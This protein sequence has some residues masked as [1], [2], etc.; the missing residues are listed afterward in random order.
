[1][2]KIWYPFT[3]TLSVEAVHV[4]LTTVADSALAVNA[5]GTVGGVVSGCVVAVDAADWAE[6]LPAASYAA[7]V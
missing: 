4:R 5:E 3:P 7:T 1:M 6:V 2:R